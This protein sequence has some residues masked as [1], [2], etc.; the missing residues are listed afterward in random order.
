[1]KVKIAHIIYTDV[2]I[3]AS[4]IPKLRGYFAKRYPKE[5][6]F[7]NHT[8]DGKCIYQNPQIQYRV[9]D[10]H[11]ALIAYNDGVNIL[12]DILLN[13]ESITIGNETHS[14]IEKEITVIISELGQSDLPLDYYF[15]TPWMALNEDNYRAYRL[16]D[17]IE[18][19]MFLRHILRENLKTISKAFGYLIPDVEAIK[20]RGM[21]R[22]MNVNFKNQ[23]MQCFKGS[24]QVNFHIPPH[25]G[26][27]KQS[28]RGF[29]VVIPVRRHN[30]SKND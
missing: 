25:L 27:G 18:Q 4:S 5:Q 2:E 28:S 21:F 9:I 22:P 24:F 1:M 19:Q 23:R 14:A 29:G 3:N 15:N 17:E 12:R 7:H 13:N 10:G 8:S 26:L 30:D 20:V 6:L 11:P 16:M